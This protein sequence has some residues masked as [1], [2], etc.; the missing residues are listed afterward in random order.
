MQESRL[1]G[2]ALRSDCSPCEL[3]KKTVKECNGRK[4]HNFVSPF[5]FHPIAKSI[6][7]QKP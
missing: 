2:Q 6:P 5:F 4:A 7:F 1:K 3:P